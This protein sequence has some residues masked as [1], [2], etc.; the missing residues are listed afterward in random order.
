MI[1]RERFRV[2]YIKN[3]LT[4]LASIQRPEQIVLYEMPSP[5]TIDKR[6]TENGLSDSSQL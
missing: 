6:L 1:C 5:A 3:S 4:Q 2:R